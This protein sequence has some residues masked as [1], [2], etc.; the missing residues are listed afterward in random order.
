MELQPLS[1]S[2]PCVAAGETVYEINPRWTATGRGQVRNRSK[3]D[4]LAAQAIALLVWRE[5]NQL[6]QV[7]A[8]DET[9]LLDL[10]VTEREPAQAEAVHLRGHLHSLLLQIDPQY[11]EHLPVLVSQK[12]GRGAGVRQH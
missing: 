8:D 10:L 6:P 11:A 5:A 3:S 7:G 4:S 2:R 9:V 1:R 12:S